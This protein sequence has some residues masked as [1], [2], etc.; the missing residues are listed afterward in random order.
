MSSV[1]PLAKVYIDALCGRAI[2]VHAGLK[3]RASHFGFEPFR[4]TGLVAKLWFARPAHTELVAL[5]CV[6]DFTAVGAMRPGGWVDLPPTEVVGKIKSVAAMLGAKWQTEDQIERDAQKVVAEIT[7]C[8]Q[9]AR[10][11]GGLKEV[12]AEYKKYRQMQI[13]KAEPAI[14]YSAHL[15]NFTRLLVVR[16]AQKSLG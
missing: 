11:N 16:A 5:R 4:R 10:L 9:L 6:Q 14:P 1:A 15:T 2:Y 3:R 8:V 7:Q 12:N 13:A